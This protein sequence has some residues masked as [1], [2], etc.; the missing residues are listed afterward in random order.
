MRARHHQLT[1]DDLIRAVAAELLDAINA[2]REQLNQLERRIMRT[3]DE[4]LTAV[5]DEGT[6]IAGIST[7]V[8]GLQQQVADAL[9]GATIPPDVQTKID[10][11]FDQA[12][13]NKQAL[14]D[15]I[16]TKPDGTAAPV[17]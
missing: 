12:T 15:A 4:T 5:Q 9:A 16:A 3:I 1:G 2:V 11:V 13:A 6:Q 7:F 8:K 10:A 14:A 17:A